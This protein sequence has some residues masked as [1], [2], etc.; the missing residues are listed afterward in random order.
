VALNR[1]PGTVKARVTVLR[2]AAKA[3]FSV[4]YEW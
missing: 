4:A 3:E 1:S 2:A